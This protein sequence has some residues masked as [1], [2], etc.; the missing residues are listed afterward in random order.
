[1]L[2]NHP[3]A[4]IF[5][6]QAFPSRFH[7]LPGIPSPVPNDN[8]AL[9]PYG[10]VDD[11]AT[12]RVKQLESRV[13]IAEKSN[14]TLLEEVVRL[15]TELRGTIKRNEEL[16]REERQSRV[17]M[18]N[19]M[20]MSSEMLTQLNVRLQM[21]ED[22]ISDERSA[23]NSIVNQQKHVEQAVLTSQQEILSRRDLHYTK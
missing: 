21:T 23:V 10:Y 8:N 7:Q 4:C 1:M 15:Q 14:R 9:V 5:R 11:T 18:E 19:N 16:I 17:D 20:R 12:E 22:R 6:T 2:M 3:C 13:A